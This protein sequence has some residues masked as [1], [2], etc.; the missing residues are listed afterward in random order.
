[1]TAAPP[2]PLAAPRADHPPAPRADQAAGL[3]SLVSS[4]Q[5][6][7]APPFAVPS[8]SVRN[9]AST[10]SV[11]RAKLITI[12]SGKGGVGKTN[13]AV[14][15]AI[16]LA[17]RGHR[18]VLLDADLGTANADV[19][20][21]LTPR[22]RINLAQLDARALASLAIDA[23][24]NFKLIPGSCGIPAATPGPDQLTSLITAIHGAA[25]A[26]SA[27]TLI[28]DAAAGIGDEVRALVSAADLALIVTT[29]EPTALADAYSLIKS[30]ALGD[31]GASLFI[32]SSLIVN[33]A[34]SASEAGAIHTRLSSVCERFLGKPLP[35]AGWIA[36]DPRVA[37]AVR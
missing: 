11:G 3:R 23:P 33:Q 14:N 17:A 35:Y 8:S 15:L 4:L 13:I 22:A 21:G 30:I 18:I 2:S 9:N 34:R 6:A 36:H 12:A 19:L 16:A 32:N 37:A 7:P 1:M 25:H 10:A 5:S 20:C 26:L 29:P 31:K 24:G 27:G 28:V